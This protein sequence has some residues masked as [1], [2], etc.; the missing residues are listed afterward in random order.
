VF[1]ASMTKEELQRYLSSTILK[2]VHAPHHQDADP[3]KSDGTVRQRG[4]AAG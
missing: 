2:L 1:L 3:E 4:W